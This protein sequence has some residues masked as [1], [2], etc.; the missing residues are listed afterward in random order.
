MTLSPIDPARFRGDG[1]GNAVVRG[2]LAAVAALVLAPSYFLISPDDLVWIGV[3]PYTTIANAAGADGRFVAWGTLKALEAIGFGYGAYMAL[4]GVA[5]VAACVF[6]LEEIFAFIGVASPWARILGGALY[7]TFSFNQDLFQFKEALSNYAQS[8]ALLA[9]ALS[10][11]RSTR[12]F[13]PRV[14]ATAVC[15]TLSLGSYQ[16]SLQILLLIMALLAI[17]KLT[18][19]TSKLFFDQMAVAA[20]AFAIAMIAYEVINRTLKLIQPGSFARY[21][22]RQPALENAWSHFGPYLRTLFD[23]FSPTSTEYAPITNELSTILTVALL[24]GGGAYL[25]TCIASRRQKAALWIVLALALLCAPNPANLLLKVYGPSPRTV[26]GVGFFLAGIAALAIDRL[27]AGAGRVRGFV[28][29]LPITAA[30]L[31]AAQAGND[32]YL[33]GRR[34]LQ[35]EADIAL[36]QRIADEAERVAAT[37][38][39]PIVAE[40]IQSWDSNLIFSNAPYGFGI[41][42]FGTPWSG[43]GMLTMFSGGAVVAKKGD[44]SLCDSSTV[45]FFPTITRV[46][47]GVVRIC[48]SPPQNYLRVGD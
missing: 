2:I 34:F 48:F 11:I 4:G 40:F 16:T 33:D 39:R 10:A 46:A 35:Q 7:L 27:I 25:T 38:I 26:A 22:I 14:A 43:E 5:L 20:A 24:L 23:V 21:P 32:L 17:A 47:D 29:A 8:F 19:T 41:G 36:A 12:P 45:A 9:L 37:N 13:V 31:V 1:Q 30:I 18:R 3:K 28:R 44:R 42:L 15:L 6:L